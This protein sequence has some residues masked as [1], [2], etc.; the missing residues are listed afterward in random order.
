MAVAELH[1]VIGRTL[2]RG[3]NSLLTWKEPKTGWI[4]RRNCSPPP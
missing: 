2:S 3:H 4:A 1:H